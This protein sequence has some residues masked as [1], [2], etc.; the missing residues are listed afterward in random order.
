MS[1][2]EYNHHMSNEPTPTEKYLATRFYEIAVGGFMQ[3][4]Y[5]RNLAVAQ[6]ADLLAEYRAFIEE[7]YFDKPFLTNN[8]DN[9]NDSPTLMNICPIKI[10]SQNQNEK[11]ID[12]ILDD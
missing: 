1:I 10:E 8:A 5:D 6:L 12:D 4:R 9:K 2:S 3:H 11:L 7:T